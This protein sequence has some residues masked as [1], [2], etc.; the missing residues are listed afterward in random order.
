MVVKANKSYATNF[1]II[2]YTAS[3]SD[4]D[5]FF[6]QKRLFGAHATEFHRQSNFNFFSRSLSAS[7]TRAL[8]R[9]ETSV[10]EKIVLVAVQADKEELYR[11]PSA[12][13]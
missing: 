5:M 12:Y 4:G 7:S 2:T 1:C 11:G 6:E 3:I 9:S 13:S 8:Q 10:G